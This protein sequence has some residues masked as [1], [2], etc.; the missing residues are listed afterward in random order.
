MILIHQ[1]KILKFQKLVF[2]NI[3]RK[4]NF[5]LDKLNQYSLNKNY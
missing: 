3:L 2:L 5:P 4:N 1:F